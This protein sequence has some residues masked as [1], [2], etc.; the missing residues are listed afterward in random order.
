MGSAIPWTA[1]TPPSRGCW[2]ATCLPPG[3]PRAVATPE[4][5]GV[6]ADLER[7]HGRTLAGAGRDHRRTGPPGRRRH[8]RLPRRMPAPR[9]A[10]LADRHGPLLI[11]DEIAT[12]FGRTGELFAAEHAGVVPDIMC[13]GK[14]LTGGYLTLAA[15][16]CTGEVAATVSGGR[17]APCCTAPPSWATRWPVRWPTPASA[18]SPAAAG[19]PTSPGSARACG[20]ARPRPGTGGRPGRPHPRRRRRHRA[21][22]R[23]RRRRRHR[24]GHPPRGLGAPVPEPRLHHAPVHQHR[25]RRRTDHRG[26]DRGR[27]RGPRARSRHGP[28]A[29]H[30]RLD[31]PSGWSGR[32]RSGTAGAWSAGRS[33]VPWT[34]SSSIWPATTIW[35]SRRIRG[36]RRPPLRPRR[37]GAR[38]PRPRAWSP[39]PPG[40]ILTWSRN[41]HAW[42]GWKR[43]SCSPPAI[44]RTSV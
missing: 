34:N 28:E 35:A 27:R 4:P 24:R 9:C 31:E 12:G 2:P 38:A 19:G 37:C 42:P 23:R 32:P 41:W 15:M 16:L 20:R 44:W 5:P 3:R 39:E 1:C 40:S 36:L 18:S 10:G 25:G 26:H 11:F 13:V 7:H 8:V 29:R 14:A 43:R 33:P 21:P 30:E 17:P 6:G 22:R